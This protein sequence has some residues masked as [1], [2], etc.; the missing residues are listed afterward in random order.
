MWLDKL[1]RHYGPRLQVNWKYFSLEQVNEDAGEGRN[2]WDEPP[3]YKPRGL[4]AF[5]AAE[6][7]RRQGAAAF[8]RFH[9]NLLIERHEKGRKSLTQE[10]IDDAARAAGLDLDRLHR[11]MA[12][13][14][15]LQALARDHT[16]AVEQFGVFGTPTI[17]FEG[18]HPVY[19]KMR[20]APPAGEEVD[21]FESVRRLATE[22]EY[23]AEIK[24]PMPGRR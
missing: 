15:V 2:I 20:P 9:L 4:L 19:L 3:G 17:L 7:S 24:R 18:G 21:V 22:R 6:A 12:D 11:D 23:I 13:P 14:A 16:E 5:K 1:G 8:E 10:V